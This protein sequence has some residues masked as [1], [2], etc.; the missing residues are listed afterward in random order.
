M[1]GKSREV[2]LT[3]TKDDLAERL[4]NN[5]LWLRAASRWGEM[6]DACDNS[7]LCEFYVQR[8]EYCISE[9]N[10]RHR[11]R[12]AESNLSADLS[13]IKQ[14]IDAVYRVSNLGPVS[15]WYIEWD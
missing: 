11:A 7:D 9:S 5:S 12:L 3:V 13:L 14:R 1:R 2:M 6:I 15:Y 10:E 4:E 8:R